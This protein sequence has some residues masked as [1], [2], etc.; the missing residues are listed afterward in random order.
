MDFDQGELD[1]N[2]SGSEEGYRKWQRE[3]DEKKRAFEGRHGIILGRQVRVQLL[4]ESKEMEGTVHLISKRIP[5]S[6]AQLRLLVG[7]REFTVAEIE[8]IVR[9]E[10]SREN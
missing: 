7:L 8:S 10:E 6:S 9:I 4:G 2:G 3:L 5:G 1:F